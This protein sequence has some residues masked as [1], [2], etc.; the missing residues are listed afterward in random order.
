M[1]WRNYYYQSNH[2]FLERMRRKAGNS[3]NLEIPHWIPSRTLG[4][5]DIFSVGLSY[6]PLPAIACLTLPLPGNQPI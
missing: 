3:Q 6:A 5:I 4:T 1:Y 2:R